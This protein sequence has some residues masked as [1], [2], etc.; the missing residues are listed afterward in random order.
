MATQLHYD[1][2]A[3]VARLARLPSKLRVV[4]AALCAERQLPNYIQFSERSGLG[5]PHVLKEALESIWQ[6]VQGRPLTKAEL[7]TMLERCDALTPTGEEDT[8]EESAYAEDA[9]AS[10]A[11]TISARLTDDPQEA[12]WAARRA[13]DA[14]DH[15]LM[16]QIDSTRVTREHEQFILSHPLVQAELQRQQADLKD[17]ESASAEKSLL[18]SVVSKLRDRARRDAELFLSTAPRP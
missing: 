4:F 10:L 16:S 3:L 6:E 5:N 8:E 11:Y 13:Y 9:G 12:A 14:L 17:L 15:F 1:E 7:E 18:A 2:P